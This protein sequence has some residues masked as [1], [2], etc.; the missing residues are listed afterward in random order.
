VLFADRVTQAT[1]PA[2]SKNNTIGRTTNAALTWCPAG[3]LLA[4]LVPVALEPS[5][6]VETLVGVRATPPPPVEELSSDE[7]VPGCTPLA[8][9]PPLLPAVADC[10]LWV[11]FWSPLPAAVVVVSVSA[12][13]FYCNAS[14]ANLTVI[15]SKTSQRKLYGCRHTVGMTERFAHHQDAKTLGDIFETIATTPRPTT[16][17]PEFWRQY[18][19]Y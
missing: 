1:K 11:V 17:D 16:T 5:W 18:I 2:A 7:V 13:P 6:T 12:I 4:A 3:V 15:L 8:A 19:R 9:V 14:V 10:G